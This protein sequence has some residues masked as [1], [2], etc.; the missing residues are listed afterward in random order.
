MS[1][2]DL[3]HWL[4]D[5]RAFW[6]TDSVFEA[7]YRRICSD[8]DI[9]STCD[10]GRLAELW[11]RRV[12][13]ELAQVLSGIPIEPGWTCLE[14]GCGIGRLMRPIAQCCRCVIG[15]DLSDRMVGYAT[16]HLADV[17][18]AEVHLNDGCSLAMVADGSV[19]WVYSHLTFQHITLS[20]VVEAYLAEIARVLRPG[21]YCRIQC[22]REA[23]LPWLQRA[24]NA[25]RRLLGREVYHGPRRWLW[26]PGREVKF[27]GITY[28]PR[29]WRQLLR[30]HGLRVEQMELGRGHDYWMWTTSRRMDGH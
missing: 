25:G 18:N 28:H 22:W 29:Q 4:R 19:D 10:E 26:A 21:G 1:T 8:P 20:E 13:A 23:P 9:E 30:A 15:V 11:D 2:T 24:K 6:D 3:S 27:G 16:E 12:E 17:P 14:I 7:K 5:T